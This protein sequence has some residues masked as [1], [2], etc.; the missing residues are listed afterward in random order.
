MA[1]TTESFQFGIDNLYTVPVNNPLRKYD[2]INGIINR[3]QEIRKVVINEKQDFEEI[4]VAKERYAKRPNYTSQHAPFKDPTSMLVAVREN[5]Y[6]AYIDK[7][8]EYN[9]FDEIATINVESVT[10]Y[11]NNYYNYNDLGFFKFRNVLTCIIDKTTLLRV[12]FMDLVNPLLFCESYVYDDAKKEIVFNS[13]Y[14]G[15][16]TVKAYTKDEFINI[17]EESSGGYFY[18][19]NSSYDLIP[20]GKYPG[21]PLYKRITLDGVNNDFDTMIVAGLTIAVPGNTS[22]VLSTPYEESQDGILKIWIQPVQ[23][24]QQFLHVAFT[25]KWNE[26]IK[27][28]YELPV[29][30]KKGTKEYSSDVKLYTSI[31]QFVPLTDLVEV[32]SEDIYLE[33]PTI[34]E[35]IFPLTE[36]IDRAK[37]KTLDKV[38][39]YYLDKSFEADIAFDSFTNT[40]GVKFITDPITIPNQSALPT[41][42]RFDLSLAAKDVAGMNPLLFLHGYS[43][44]AIYR[45]PDNFL[46]VKQVFTEPLV[47]TEFETKKFRI[48]FKGNGTLTIQS[49]TLKRLS[50][51][52]GYFKPTDFIM[53]LVSKV[54]GLF[55]YDLTLDK[56][57]FLNPQNTLVDTLKFAF[58]FKTV[59]EDKET[60]VYW[61][62]EVLV[63]DMAITYLKDRYTLVDVEYDNVLTGIGTYRYLL[64][65]KALQKYT[66]KYN[67]DP[68]LIP[69]GKM[70]FSANTTPLTDVMDWD[71]RDG[72]WSSNVRVNNYGNLTLQYVDVV[73]ESN[74]VT[75]KHDKPVH[76]L[77]MVNRPTTLYKNATGRVYFDLTYTDDISAIYVDGASIT[78]DT[79]FRHANSRNGVGA[80]SVVYSADNKRI[81]GL[82]VDITPIPGIT[83]INLKFDITQVNDYDYTKFPLSINIKVP[84]KPQTEGPQFTFRLVNFAF[85][86]ESVGI[87]SLKLPELEDAQVVA[88]IINTATNLVV[89]YPN[90]DPIG[91]SNTET[92]NL[93]IDN[94]LN[95]QKKYILSIEVYEYENAA[96][97]NLLPNRLF[98]ITDIPFEV[99]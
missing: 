31:N 14:Y 71:F 86:K 23:N 41:E 8:P 44:S 36:Y 57:I 73:A 43:T 9:P 95:K 13:P 12:K 4:Q 28:F 80:M 25:P 67:T 22:K 27:P 78:K 81:V 97:D 11:M 76:P 20:L 1:K 18:V 62:G 82:G 60:I 33:V 90:F 37:I 61:P 19:I 84:V 17:D 54:D 10:E 55:T 83:T 21:Y 40:G 6:M 42:I 58:E 15:D 77:K 92:K 39:G 69:G 94:A 3:Y 29:T 96:K 46:R 64:F 49:V 63:E 93:F 91:E 16:I 85:G 34:Y 30:F 72:I 45:V 51:S 66:D 74:V 5:G 88:K 38:K 48:T 99:P 2:Y 53:T 87:L 65:D 52:L 75:L 70:K 47:Y 59:K 7:V 98:Y 89:D 26:D 68:R 79:L 35:L 24:D 50:D 56:K 32:N